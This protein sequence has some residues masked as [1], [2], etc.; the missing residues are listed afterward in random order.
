MEKA[1][2]ITLSLPA[3]NPLLATGHI[4][5]DPDTGDEHVEFHVNNHDCMQDFANERYGAI[6]GNRKPLIIFGQDGSF[7]NQFS[8]NSKQWVGPFGKRSILPKCAGMGVMVSVFQSCE[9]GWG[10]LFYQSV[11]GWE[12]WYQ[13]FKVVSLGGVWILM[14]ISSR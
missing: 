13:C 3:S 7:F 12:L 11:L 10:I 4:Y 5:A 9:F 2:I 1:K 14:T 6:G 8:F